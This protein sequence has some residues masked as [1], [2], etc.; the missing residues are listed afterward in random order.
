MSSPHR[1]RWADQIRVC[2]LIEASRLRLKL[3]PLMDGLS[4]RPV[5]SGL[6]VFVAQ[7]ETSLVVGKRSLNSGVGRLGP[8]DAM[9]RGVLR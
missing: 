3:L 1:G 9:C 4:V 5:V 8:T 6:L 7:T 2:L